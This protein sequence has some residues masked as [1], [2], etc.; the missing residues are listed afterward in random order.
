[1]S[2]LVSPFVEIFRYALTPIAPFTWFGVGLS[3]LDIV[4]TFRL[5]IILRQLREQIQ[6]KH[7]ST[8]GKAGLEERSFVKA[9]TATLLVVYGGEAITGEYISLCHSCTKR[10]RMTL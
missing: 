7:V 10:L 2:I 3:T 5:C 8:K 6:A 4:A 1:M 9:L